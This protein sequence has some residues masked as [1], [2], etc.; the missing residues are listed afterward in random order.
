MS[1]SSLFNIY[2]IHYPIYIILYSIYIILYSIYIILYS[3]Y[4]ILSDDYEENCGQSILVTR[5]QPN[6]V[7]RLTPGKSVQSLCDL[8]F[9][10]NQEGAALELAFVV[11]TWVV[12]YTL[13]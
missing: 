7:V 2:I 4:I 13:W 8:E 10:V 9:T 6:G 12:F 3:I 1:V 11:R 5:T